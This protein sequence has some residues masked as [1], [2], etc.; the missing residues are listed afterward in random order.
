MKINTLHIIFI[1]ILYE[2]FSLFYVVSVRF[3][4]L[5]CIVVFV[6]GGWNQLIRIYV[7]NKVL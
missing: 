7:S 5:S 2:I 6:H 4:R 1:M 3:D